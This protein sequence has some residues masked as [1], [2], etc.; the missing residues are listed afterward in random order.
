VKQSPLRYRDPKGLNPE[1]NPGL[2]GPPRVFPPDVVDTACAGISSVQ[3]AAKLGCGRLAVL[4]YPGPGGDRSDAMRHCT[5][6]CCMAKFIG[7]RS[8]ADVGLQH[9][10]IFP[11]GFRKDSDKIN[12]LKMDLCNNR[13]G[14]RCAS[15]T[16]SPSCDACCAQAPLTTSISDP[17]RDGGCR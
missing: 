15:S 13:H 17:C 3:C 10:I 12:D 4:F 16:S 8:A 1:E 14:R 6:S 2:P 11:P 7:D 5:W 9:E